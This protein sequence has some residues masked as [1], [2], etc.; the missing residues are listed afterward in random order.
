MNA[1]RDILEGTWEE[2]AGQAGH[3][4]GRRVRVEVIENGLRGQEAEPLPFYATAT[5]EERVRALREW[6]ASH[7]LDTVFLS[8]DAISRD[9]IYFGEE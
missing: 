2:I 1:A 8:D 5:K 3:L 6:A 4:A 7:L 9:S